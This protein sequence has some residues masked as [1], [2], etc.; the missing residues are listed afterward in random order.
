MSK[1]DYVDFQERTWPLAYLITFRSYGT[2][3]HGE[4]RGSIDR[5]N[6]HRYGTPDM[7][8]NEKLVDDERAELKNPAIL[9]NRAQRDVVESAIREV[10]E[11]RAYVLHAISV[12]TNHVHSV[13]SASCEPEHVMDSFK[14]YATRK[15][16][17]EDLLS[18]DVK[19]WA[20]HGSTP[21]LWTEEE[22]QRA[23]N[24]VING[25]GDE[26]FS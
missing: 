7:P 25:Q 12:R 16:R 4:E 20:R 14:A 6:Y 3:L 24:Y 21:Y 2:W 17:E 1:I 22:I 13:V 18:R 26:P 10:C 5:R 19:P 11:H 23:I 15:L 9:L 8:A